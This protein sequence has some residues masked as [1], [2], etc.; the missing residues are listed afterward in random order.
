LERSLVIFFR[1]PAIFPSPGLALP[2]AAAVAGFAVAL[3]FQAYLAFHSPLVFPV[4]M[5]SQVALEK[6]ESTTV[7]LALSG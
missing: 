6:S 7:G 3:S 5:E 1:P 2:A 4:K